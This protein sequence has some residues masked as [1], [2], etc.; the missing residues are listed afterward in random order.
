MSGRIVRTVLGDVD[1]GT[2]GLVLGHEHL[3]TH[4][5][6]FVTDPDLTM[7]SEAE[8]LA[9]LADF[10]AAGGGGLVEMTT[11]DYGRDGPALVRL[12]RAS[13]VHVVAATGFNQG[14]FADRISSRFS[15]EAIAAWM[16]REVA[17]GLVAP[18]VE[19]LDAPA[20]AGPFAA[21]AGLIKASSGLDGPGDDER[22]VLEAAALAHLRTGAPIS[23]HTEKGTWALEQARLL[24]GAGVP[25]TSILLSHLDLKPDLGYLLEVLA[26][27]VSIG[28]DQFGKAKYLPDADRVALVEA[29]AGRGH[30]DQ[31]MLS[32][33]MARRSSW[34]STGGGPGLAHIPRTILPMLRE[35]GFDAD[36][37][38]RLTVGNAARF[39]AFAPAGGAG[40]APPER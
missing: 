22:R 37:M 39:L 31:L 1:P 15:T 7:A 10:A 38:T 17:D 20:L 35:R 14:K 16:A 11:I 19:S 9:E 4:P 12:S 13:G 18:G 40:G 23:T 6:A 32:G 27:G 21:R 2:L 29:L 24:T 33:D 36:A 5:P 28:L 34:R 25:S 26:T 30:L 8:A 3:V